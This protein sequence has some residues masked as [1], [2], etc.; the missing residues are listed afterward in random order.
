MMTLW[1]RGKRQLTIFNCAISDLFFKFIFMLQMASS[2]I[3]CPPL[4]ART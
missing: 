3:N 1:W 2:L 4:F